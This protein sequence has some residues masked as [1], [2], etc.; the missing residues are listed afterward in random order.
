VHSALHLPPVEKLTQPTS[1]AAHVCN[2]ITGR[3][4]ITDRLNKRKFLV[5]TGFDLCVYPRRFI[6]RSTEQVNYDLCAANGTTI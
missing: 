4:F 1:K 3:L 6:Q 5:D 2:T